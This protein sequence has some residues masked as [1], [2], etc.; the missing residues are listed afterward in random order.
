[1]KLLKPYQEAISSLLIDPFWKD[2][3][4]DTHLHGISLSEYNKV[5]KNQR[6]PKMFSN[7]AVLMNGFFIPLPCFLDRQVEEDA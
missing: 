5:Y 6:I 7:D 2:S 3:I 1:M 4:K